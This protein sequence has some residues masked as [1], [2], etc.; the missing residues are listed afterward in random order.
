MSKFNPNIPTVDI[1]QADP[2][3]GYVTLG[4]VAG[5]PPA[6]TTYAGIFGLECLLQDSDGA[7]VYQQSGTVASPAWTLIGATSSHVI[8]YAGTATGG[9]TA[10]RAYTV[11]GAAATDVVSA[12]IRASTNATTIQKA[13]LTADTLTV[14]FAADPGASTT[15]DYIICRAV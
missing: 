14:I 15:V 3:T 10:T 1:Q 9:T 4:V 7:G 8:K 11:T 6:G 5:T 2:V 13:T 12:V